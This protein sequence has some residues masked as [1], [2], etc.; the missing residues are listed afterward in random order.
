MFGKTR[1][2]MDLLRTNYAVRV[3]GGM[4]F[5]IK[6]IQLQIE[7]Y[8][9]LPQESGGIPSQAVVFADTINMFNILLRGKILEVIQTDY[10]QLY[11]M[12]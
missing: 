5:I 7:R 10:P 11:H 12:V 4:E 6:M 8:F 2:T 9:E 1:Y 3:P